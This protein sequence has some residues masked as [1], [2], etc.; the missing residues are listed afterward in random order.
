[1]NPFE[2]EAEVS[3]FSCNFMQ[4]KATYIIYAIFFRFKLHLKN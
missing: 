1:M 3:D 4:H 2:S